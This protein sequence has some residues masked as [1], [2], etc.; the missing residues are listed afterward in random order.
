MRFAAEPATRR[1]SSLPLMHP[2]APLAEIFGEPAYILAGF[3]GVAVTGLAG[4]LQWQLTWLCSDVE[5]AEKDAKITAAQAKSRMWVLRMAG[6]VL[7]ALGVILIV[8]AAIGYFRRS[9]V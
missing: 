7:M 5:E 8:L 2:L 1:R 9:A 3:A 4:W 6:P